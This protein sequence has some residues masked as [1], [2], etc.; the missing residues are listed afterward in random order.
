M[1]RKKEPKPQN[2]GILEQPISLKN[3]SGVPKMPRRPTIIEGKEAEKQYQQDLKRHLSLSSL[4]ATEQAISNLPLLLKHYGISEEDAAKW[5][6]LSLKLAIEFVPGF[7]LAS[8]KPYGP[9]KKW[10]EGH[11]AA[12]YLDVFDMRKDKTKINLENMFH[13]LSRE[14]PWKHL[15][16]PRKSNDTKG[17]GKRLH[18][19]YNDAMSGGFGQLIEWL[20]T[21]Q[22][23]DAQKRKREFLEILAGRSKKDSR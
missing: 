23:P 11:L 21:L 13:E 2:S 16:N 18:N 1:P 4:A 22:V 20:D 19:I 15:C 10:H 9:K 17:S 14:A 12:L 8:A 7:S 3:L 6:I 5:E